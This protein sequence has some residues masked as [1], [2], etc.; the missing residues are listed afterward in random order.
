MDEKREASG[1]ATGRGFGSTG[2]TRLSDAC[3][4][5]HIC[6]KLKAE[7]HQMGRERARR[8]MRKGSTVH[9]SG[10]RAMTEAG[11]RGSVGPR[12]C[13]EAVV[14]GV[15][16]SRL[17]LGAL[18]AR[19]GPPHCS[20]SLTPAHH[21]AGHSVQP[22]VSASCPVAMA[23]TLSPC[24][25]W[26]RLRSQ[27]APHPHSRA[28]PALPAQLGAE[29]TVPIGLGPE[30]G[31]ESED[32]GLGPCSATVWP[33]ADNFPSLGY[34]SKMVEHCPDGSIS[35]AVML[36]DNSTSSEKAPWCHL[37]STGSGVQ[38]A[39]RGQ[40][41]APIHS[42]STF[43]LQAEHWSGSQKDWFL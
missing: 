2:V 26:A 16:G 14:Q 42:L 21:T 23:L 40:I 6:P 3:L 38:G 39:E 13:G 11:I 12:G 10:H 7:R 28:G 1:E 20:R 18:A 36:S 43:C 35:G 41:L 37:E 8:I 22:A 15:R 31:A 19:G 9:T 17:P 34:V 4:R 24:P 30:L 29:S 27:G 32:L 5:S 25:P 33:Q